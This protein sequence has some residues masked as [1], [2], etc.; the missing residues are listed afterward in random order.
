LQFNEEHGD[1][2]PAGW[3][4]GDSGMQPTAEGVADYL[5]SKSEKL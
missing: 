5:S 3:Q 2:C 1:V 4:K